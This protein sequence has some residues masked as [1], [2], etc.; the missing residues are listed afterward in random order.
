MDNGA[1]GVWSV[2]TQRS[3]HQRHIARRIWERLVDEH[4]ATLAEST[5]RAYVGRL[6]SG[7]R[8]PGRE[9]TE[10]SMLVMR[11]SHSGRALDVCF[12]GEGQEAF[13]ESHAAPFHTRQVPER[14]ERDGAET[15]GAPPERVITRQRQPARDRGGAGR[16]LAANAMRRLVS[17]VG[18]YR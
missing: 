8:P 13:P 3:A 15:E 9:L 14:F 10:R 6:R 1:L 18:G 17:P 12:S 11:F 7:E 16:H 5:V 4:G 2:L